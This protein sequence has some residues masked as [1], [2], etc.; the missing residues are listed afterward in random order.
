MKD[1][2][3]LEK[4]EDCILKIVDFAKAISLDEDNVAAGGIAL[5]MAEE[6]RS[7]STKVLDLI[8]SDM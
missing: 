6:I 8:K 3:K 4:I 1:T 5:T 7:Y 2:K